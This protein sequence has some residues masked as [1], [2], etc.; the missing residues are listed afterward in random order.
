MLIIS[1]RWEGTC[2]S[3]VLETLS[4]GRFLIEG[5]T[6]HRR[7]AGHDNGMFDVLQIAAFHRSLK[8]KDEDCDDGQGGIALVCLGRVYACVG[9]CTYVCV[10]A[11]MTYFPRQPHPGVW[12][13][14]SD[15]LTL[16]L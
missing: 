10:E 16:E 6:R 12:H 13:L 11:S 7:H 1:G 15:T 8:Q 4:Y 5:L 9:V 14:E 3:D 2:T